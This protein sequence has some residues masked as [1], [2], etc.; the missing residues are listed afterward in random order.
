MILLIEVRQLIEYFATS[1]RL[2]VTVVVETFTTEATGK[3]EVLLHDSHARGV[4]G[5]EVSI[6]EETSEVA[7]SCLLKGQEGCA[8]ES[9]LRVDTIADGSDESLEGGLRKHEVGGL[10]VLLDLSDGDCAGSESELALLLDSTLGGG[11]L[12]ASLISLAS[13]GAGG[14][15]GLGDGALDGFLS[16]DLLSWHLYIFLIYKFEF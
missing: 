3:V 11:S 13:L 7:L 10:L 4:D 2:E 1:L 5:A 14:N 6:L 8:L 16:C 9:E 15:A 12:L